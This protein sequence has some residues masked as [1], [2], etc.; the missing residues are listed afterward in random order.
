MKKPVYIIG[1]KNPD[2]DTIVSAIAYAEFKKLHKIEAIPARLGSTNNET[3]FLLEKFGFED[4]LRIY[5]A[6]SLLNEIEMDKASIVE[7][8]VTMKEAL[9]KVLKIKNKVLFVADKKK[10]LEGLLSLD[11]L[12]YMWTKTDAQLEQIIK[13]IKTENVIKTLE[14][15]LVL[16]G[17]RALSGKMHIFP[18]LKSKVANDSIVLLRNEDDKIEYCLN[19]GA[20]LIIVVTSVPISKK[21]L[22][23]AKE[24]DATIVTTS[25]SPLSVTR[26][27]YQT[28]TIENVMSKKEKIVYFNDDDTVQDASKKILM[29][30]H[31]SYPVVNESGIIIGALSRFH[32]FNYQKKQL[33]LVDH[34]EHKQTIDDI[35]DGEVLEIV[36]HHRL[37]GFESDNP[38]TI[39]TRPVGSTTTIVAQLFFENNFKINKKLAG[40]MLGAII[41]DT[42]NFKSPTTTQ[43]DIIVAKQL[44]KL[45][46][47]KSSELSKQMVEHSDSLLSKRLIEIVYDDFKEFTI[48]GNKVG[49]SQAS[50]KSKDEFEKIK[51]DLQA[52]LEDS[53]KSGSYDLMII[54]LTNPNGSGS[55]ILSAGNRKNIV[56]G[57][58]N[59]NKKDDY[60][61]GLLSRKKQLLPAVIKAIGEK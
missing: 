46:G 6:R 34:N 21:V 22:K 50:C 41:S 4:P 17:N 45:S 49:L 1:H 11:D 55:Y 58:F 30:R 8:N 52:Y 26:L 19:L 10:H 3:E 56:K 60:I 44:E 31:R 24:K 14:G 53:C 42:I 15:K 13:T 47:V 57:M 28:P 23:M 51:K 59:N 20:S 18:S 61:K 16:K 29:S 36:D 35:D 48:E 43:T 39:I 37:G 54:M 2:T 27:I 32:L 7:R 9:E 40:L 33:I 38:I 12:T 25:L 5:S